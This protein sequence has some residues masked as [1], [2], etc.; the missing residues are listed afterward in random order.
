MVK[1]FRREFTN[2][3]QNP[4]A[5]AASRRRQG[6]DAELVALIPIAAGLLASLAAL[7]ALA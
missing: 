4:I 6:S 1:R 5:L 7:A 3:R 2:K